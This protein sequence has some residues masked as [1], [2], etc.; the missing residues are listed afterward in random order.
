M[1]RSRSQ[2]AWI[3]ILLLM[4]LIPNYLFSQNSSIEDPSILTVDR[5]FAS[6]EFS[7]ERFGPARWIDD[8]AG[9]TTLER[10]AGESGGRDIVRYETK[11][12]KRTILVAAEK[13]IPSGQTE[14]LSIANYI[15]SADGT[16]LMIF[17][18][19]K[20]VWRRRGCSN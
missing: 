18:N 12:G 14:P 7:Q 8:G 11:S 16:K 17:T 2:K 10:S 1:K 4:A 9:Y 13:L 3:P 15:W 5:I 20:R 6:N 19:T